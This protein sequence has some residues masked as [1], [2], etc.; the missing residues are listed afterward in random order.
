[1]NEGH[2]IKI[3]LYVL[4]LLFAMNCPAFFF[5]HP[6]S[7]NVQPNGTGSFVMM[8]ENVNGVQAL[9]INRGARPELREKT[10]LSS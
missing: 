7:M 8:L 6:V 10:I 5:S 1:M 9:D 2:D 3:K 4:G